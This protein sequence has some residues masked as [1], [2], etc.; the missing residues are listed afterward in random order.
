[1]VLPEAGA[2]PRFQEHSL[3][4]FDL[5]MLVVLGAKQRSETEFRQLLKKADDRFE[6]VKVS[7]EGSMGL[8][9]AHLKT[10]SGT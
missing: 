9:E 5:L 10:S 3:R 4:Q 8:V 6:V 1:M 7:R 2:I